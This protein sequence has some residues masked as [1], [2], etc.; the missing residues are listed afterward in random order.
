MIIQFKVTN[1]SRKQLED[2]KVLLTKDMKS[3]LPRELAKQGSFAAEASI[4]LSVPV[5]VTNDDLSLRNSIKSYAV[6]TPGKNL[7]IGKAYVVKAAEPKALA[8]ELGIPKPIYVPINNNWKGWLA[9]H[10]NLK[11]Q[12]EGTSVNNRAKRWVMRS[13]KM[14]EQLR[15]KTLERGVLRTGVKGK[16]ALGTTNKFMDKAFQRLNNEEMDSVI[17]NAIE[18]ILIRRQR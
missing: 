18:N 17:I 9:R 10:S 13:P 7:A 12:V 2:L 4:R 16:T 6:R 14:S 11:S 3:K 1:K 5:G 8:N 15:E